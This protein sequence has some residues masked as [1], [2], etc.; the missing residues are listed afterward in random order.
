QF[1]RDLIPG[2]ELVVVEVVRGVVVLH[3]QLDV[4]D[5]RGNE[6]DL[7][8]AVVLAIKIDTRL[9]AQP[10]L[11]RDGRDRHLDL[12]GIDPR[13]LTGPKAL[14][15]CQPQLPNLA[16]LH[17]ALRLDLDHAAGVAGVLAFLDHHQVALLRRGARR[18]RGD[19]HRWLANVAPQ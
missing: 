13:R 12:A 8:P 4:A 18:Q 7:E 9:R 3:P 1:G 5:Y 10:R 11:E 19:Q 6:L 14:Q 15:V 2:V 17:V 16:S